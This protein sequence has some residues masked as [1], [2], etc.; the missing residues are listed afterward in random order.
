[1]G[2]FKVVLIANDGHPIPDWVREKF[3]A[4]GVEYVYQDCH[5]REDLEECV[6]DADV[7]WLMSSRRGLVTEENMDLFPKVGAVIKCGSGTDNIDHPACTRRGILVAHTPDDPTEPASDHFIAM[8]FTAVRRTARQD[9]LIRQGRWEARAALPIGR[10]TGADL[11]LIGFGRIGRAIVR[12]L[13]GFQMNVRVYDPYV[14]AAAIEAAGARR[15]ELEELLRASQYVLVACPLTEETRGLLGEKELR[16]MRPDAVLV[17]C[18]RG[19]IVEEAALIRALQEGWIQAAALDVVEKPPLKPGDPLLSLENLNLTPH[20]GG[21]PENYPDGIFS[22]PVE[23]I[24]EMS[25]MRRPKWI[26]NPG[27]VPKWKMT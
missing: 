9:R 1:M 20:L 14:E 12:K 26:A 7:L 4:A 10:F 15:V 8:L 27:V 17:N 21:Y 13:S 23:V 11:G 16:L 18:A 5:R 6:G 25:R 2:K 19:G 22:A 3:V 24:L